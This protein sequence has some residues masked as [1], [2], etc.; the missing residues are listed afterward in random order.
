M[1][2]INTYPAKTTPVGADIVNVWDSASSAVKTVTITNLATALNGLI[3]L[4]GDVT[5]TPSATAIAAGV[6]VNADISAS[7]AIAL[8][9]LATDPLARA[10]HT[11]T[12]VLATISDAGTMASQNANA[13]AITGG[14]LAGLAGVQAVATTGGWGFTGDSNTYWGYSTTDTLAA[15]VGGSTRLTIAN[16]ASVNAAQ[17]IFDSRVR[18][19][20]A[21]DLGTLS[22]L[23]TATASHVQVNR[24]P[25]SGSGDLWRG[26]DN[27][28]TLQARIRSDG[29]VESSSMQG[30]GIVVYS[31]SLAAKTD[32]WS[33]GLNSNNLQLKDVENSSRVHASFLRG[34]DIAN[35]QT[36]LLS[37]VSLAVDA[38]YG[39]S[40][41]IG[42]HSSS[43]IAQVI[44]LASGATAHALT[45]EDNSGTDLIS[46]RSDG[47]IRWESSDSAPT[48]TVMPDA[49]IT[50]YVGATAYRMPL[51]TP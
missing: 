12:Q 29:V 21:T 30:A 45:I 40:V 23:G 32:R 10:N 51:Y 46:I 43:A 1:A 35:A 17:S 25:S 18:I 8:S 20:S 47:R 4:S 19:G 33:F 24:L 26:E 31:G 7:A 2:I 28:G 49:W 13:V 27:S 5:G 50:V 9:K 14:A 38:D 6:I 36:R 3:A 22:V 39:A 41:S 42:G 34:A 15:I 44:R 48:D 16:G 37:R 11:G